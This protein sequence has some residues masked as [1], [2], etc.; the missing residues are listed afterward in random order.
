[1]CDAGESESISSNVE[2]HQEEITTLEHYQKNSKEEESEEIKEGWEEPGEVFDKNRRD[3]T[4][5]IPDI[6]SE[7][8]KVKVKEKQNDLIGEKGQIKADGTAG[9]V[10][11]EF[12]EIEDVQECKKA[13]IRIAGMETEELSDDVDLDS[14]KDEYF[15]EEDTEF[16]ISRE[17]IDKEE[18]RRRRDAWKNILKFEE[19]DKIVRR[20]TEDLE[21]GVFGSL[22]SAARYHGIPRSTLFDQIENRGSGILG[23]SLFSESEENAICQNIEEGMKKGDYISYAYINKV[24]CAEVKRIKST[25]PKRSF[26]DSFKKNYISTFVKKKNLGRFLSK[27][28]QRLDILKG[29]YRNEC[30]ICEITFT[31][32][33]QEKA[34]NLNKHSKEKT[35]NIASTKANTKNNIARNLVKEKEGN[36][37][38]NID[39]NSTNEKEETH[40]VSEKKKIRKDKAYILE[41]RLQIR[42]AIDEIK[43]GVLKF[44]SLMSAARH[45]GIPTSTLHDALRDDGKRDHSSITELQLWCFIGAFYGFFATES[46]TYFL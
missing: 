46:A 13:S 33:I 40:S 8:E 27:N 15:I 28:Q 35:G 45:Y 11:R 44:P 39:K 24:L 7:M 23:R 9:N 31:T 42:T 36:K 4:S 1:M 30:N 21:N 14:V 34:H 5:L 20:A 18:A 26:P 38:I 12:V 43:S 32:K 17:L 29:T 19:K 25:D 37:V 16:L 6:R 10:K 22:T 3:F 41:R 2:S